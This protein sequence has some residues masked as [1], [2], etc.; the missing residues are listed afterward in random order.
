VY[1]YPPEPFSGQKDDTTFLS[2]WG[3]NFGSPLFFVG[4]PFVKHA[5]PFLLTVTGDKR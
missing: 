5:F 1:A 2:G 3:M 4:R